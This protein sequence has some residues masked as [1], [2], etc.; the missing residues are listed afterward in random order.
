MKTQG[1]K[2][3]ER[4]R[5]REREMVLCPSVIRAGLSRAEQKCVFD[6]EREF[7]RVSLEVKRMREGSKLKK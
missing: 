5:E 1:E 4:E 3:R 2:E 7:V 6:S